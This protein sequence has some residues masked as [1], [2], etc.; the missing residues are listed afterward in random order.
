MFLFI[1]YIY[2]LFQLKDLFY[3]FMQNVMKSKIQGF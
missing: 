1:L 3:A 2:M